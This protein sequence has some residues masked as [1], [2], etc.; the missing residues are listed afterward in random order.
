MIWR[1]LAVPEGCETEALDLLQQVF[2]GASPAGL[3]AAQR[4]QQE[5][6]IA[7]YLKSK[8]AV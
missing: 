3:S 6:M 8:L 7:G 5:A 1:A 4:R 2:A